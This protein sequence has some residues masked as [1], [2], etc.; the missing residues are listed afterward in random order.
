MN[1]N[2][3]LSTMLLWITKDEPFNHQIWELVNYYDISET[4]DNKTYGLHYSFNSMTE[5]EMIEFDYD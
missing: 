1:R 5:G 2:W 4:K 3:E